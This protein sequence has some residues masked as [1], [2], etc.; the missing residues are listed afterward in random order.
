MGTNF[1][2][3]SRHAKLPKGDAH[4]TN[5]KLPYAVVTKLTKTIKQTLDSNRHS[6]TVTA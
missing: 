5:K 4:C 3:D 6:D 1:T 2:K